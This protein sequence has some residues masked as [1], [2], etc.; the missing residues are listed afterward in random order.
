MVFCIYGEGWVVLYDGEV[1]YVR[2]DKI[3][4]GK[5]GETSE[6]L[7]EQQGHLDNYV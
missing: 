4:R 1:T 3:K 2:K 6:A 5:G 7:K